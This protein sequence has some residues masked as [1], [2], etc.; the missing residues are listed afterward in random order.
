[1]K[2]ERLQ[3]LREDADLTQRELGEYLHISQRAYAHYENGTRNIPVDMLIRLA[4]YYNTSVDY[5]V[6]LTDQKEPWK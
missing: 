2:F 3:A 4:R 1:M 5:L 6:G